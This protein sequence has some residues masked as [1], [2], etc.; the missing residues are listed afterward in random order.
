MKFFSILLK[1]AIPKI[2][3]ANVVIQLIPQKSQSRGVSPALLGDHHR[4]DEFAFRAGGEE[5]FPGSVVRGE[6]LDGSDAADVVGLGQGG[7]GGLRQ[8]GHFVEGPGA[9]DVKPLGELPARISG[10]SGLRGERAQLG[11]RFAQ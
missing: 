1:I 9:P 5:I 7:A 3:N 2:K 11:E 6:G 4:F 8:V 10:E